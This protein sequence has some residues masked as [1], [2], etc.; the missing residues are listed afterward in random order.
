M[1]D[2][3]LPLITILCKAIENKQR[4]RFIYSEKERI[5]EPQCCGIS[6][7][8]KG[9]VRMHLVKGGSRPEQLFQLSQIKSLEILDEHFNKPG[10]NY[11]PDDSAMK[12]IFCQL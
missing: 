1:S 7:T 8:G 11:K 2:A 12:E 10:P 6:Y 9:I 4:V 3:L 5:G